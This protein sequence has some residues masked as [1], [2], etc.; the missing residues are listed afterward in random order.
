MELTLLERLTMLGF[1]GPEGTLTYL[2]A[3]RDL[4]AK[5]GLTAD[6]ISE[7]KLTESEGGVRPENPEDWKRTIEV[8]FTGGESAIVAEALNKKLEDTKKLHENELSL[9]EKFVES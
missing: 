5:I 4:V 8:S 3:K 9:Y 1:L 2:R 7:L 6:E